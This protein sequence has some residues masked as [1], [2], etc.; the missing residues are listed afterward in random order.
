MLPSSCSSAMLWQTP[1]VSQPAIV[2]DCRR[3]ERIAESLPIFPP[4][5]VDLV[6]DYLSCLTLAVLPLQV[7]ERRVLI[8]SEKNQDIRSAIVD[9]LTSGQADP[10]IKRQIIVNVMQYKY[11]REFRILI[12]ELQTMNMQVNLDNTDLSNLRLTGIY[13]VNVSAV[14][15]DLSASTLIFANFSDAV[16]TNANL[17]GTTFIDSVL[18]NADLYGAHIDQTNFFWCSAQDL[19]TSD[20]ELSTIT[21]MSDSDLFLKGIHTTKKSQFQFRS[22]ALNSVPFRCH[23]FCVIG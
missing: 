6:E 13:L 8:K 23:D 5:L 2:E 19:I 10:K 11:Q 3:K 1:S 12:E 21:V 17:E 14:N 15:L 16:L 18:I 20:T 7:N 4:E 9:V 22:I